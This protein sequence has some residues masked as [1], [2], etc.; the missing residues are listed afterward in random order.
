[1]V[2]EGF[3]DVDVVVAAVVDYISSWC[4]VFRILNFHSHL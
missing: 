1:M 2:G 3:V 4:T